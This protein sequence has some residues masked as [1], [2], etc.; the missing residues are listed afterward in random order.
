MLPIYT[1]YLTPEHYGTLELLSMILDVVAILFGLR[2][3]EAVFRFYYKFEAQRDRD[4]VIFTALALVGL[5]N[6][7]GVVLLLSGAGIASR[8][9]FGSTEATH[10]ISLFSFTLILQ[11]I[12]E[13]V[14]T[15][16]RAQQ[17]PW[18]FVGL[19]LLKLTLQLSLNIYFVVVLRLAVEGVIY[20]NLISGVVLAIPLVWYT[21]PKTGLSFSKEKAKMMISFSLPLVL[22]SLISFYM[23]FGDR[24]FLRVFGGGLD[25]VGVYSLGYRFGFL[26]SFL[27]GDPFFSIWN[28][29]KYV[30]AG[31]PDAILRFRY[32]FLLLS[33]ALVWV[34]VGISIYVHDLLRIMSDHAFWGAAGIVPVILLGYVLQNWTGF[35]NLGILLNE[36]TGEIAK[37]TAISAVLITGSY[38][39]LIPIWGGMGAAL[40]TVIGFGGRMAWITWRANQ[41]HPLHLPWGRAFSMLLL[42][43]ATWGVTLLAPAPLLPSIAVTT[44]V[45]LVFTTIL[46]TFP[47]F[48]PGDLRTIILQA[49][50]NRRLPF[51]G[52]RQ[53]ASDSVTTEDGSGAEEG[54]A[55][56]GDSGITGVGGK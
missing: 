13:T 55:S 2:I 35:A 47:G 7:I 6:T 52:L 5:L 30:A 41:L 20:S 21:L 15:F 4:E 31:Q 22:T 44:L 10:L 25:E 36:R 34:T 11:S 42:G 16:V 27:V 23:T 14:L 40:A 37:G 3:G 8:V 18:L 1:R 50:R 12:T 46:L 9:V 33:V 45:F 39:L 32:A 24:Y 48:L 17:K 26:L 51:S 28:S 43:A 53:V 54:V 56:P 19:S 38:L 29:E 49:V